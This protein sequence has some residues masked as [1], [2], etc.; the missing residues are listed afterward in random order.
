MK[1]SPARLVLIAAAVAACSAQAQQSPKAP[2]QPQAAAA[3]SPE[4]QKLIDQVLDL[5]HI[6]EVAITM[7]QRP[8]ASA[9]EQ[10]RIALQG[11][12]SAEKQEATLKEIAKDVQKYVD[13]ATPIARDNAMRLKKPVLEPLLAQNFSDDEL[14]QLIA[15]LQSPVKKKFEQLLPSFEKAFGEKVA[16]QG[17]PQINPKIKA[18]NEAVGVKLRAAAMTQ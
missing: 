7:A 9:L 13:E 1:F 12:V 14:R 11:R 8:A 5:W 17:A 15:L 16:V 4:K 6:E 18:L 2:A 3:V 10:S